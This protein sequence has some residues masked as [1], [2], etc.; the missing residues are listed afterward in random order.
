MN[1]AHTYTKGRIQP[2]QIKAIHAAKNKHGIDQST[3]WVMLRGY[4]CKD[5]DCGDGQPPHPTSKDLT[6]SQA[7]ELLDHLNGTSG[8]SRP[9]RGR[10]KQRPYEDMDGRPGFANGAQCR[11]IAAMFAQVTRAVGEDAIE[12][13]LN[14]FCNRIVGVAGL[15]M[16]KGW[17]VEKIVKALEA[18][19]A[20]K[21]EV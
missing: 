16:V 8:A 6:W 7:E 20:V 3:Y 14:S 13:A 4:G 10:G 18:M 2:R 17:Q 21:K 12:K 15:R 9:G 11:L 1:A 19:G 5:R